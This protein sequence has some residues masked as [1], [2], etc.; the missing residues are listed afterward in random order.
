MAHAEFGECLRAVDSD[1][2]PIAVP[3]AALTLLVGWLI[4]QVEL[5]RWSE[6]EQ[7]RRCGSRRSGDGGRSGDS[8]GADPVRRWP[9]LRRTSR[10]RTGCACSR[11]AR[12]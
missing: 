1:L 6:T 8:R 9:Q 12:W 7:A 4:P 2:F 11:P 10:R 3:I 5:E